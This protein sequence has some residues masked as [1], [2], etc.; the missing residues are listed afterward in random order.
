MVPV[1][2][3][4]RKTTPPVVHLP[5]PCARRRHAVVF[6]GLSRANARGD[7]TA[8]T[9]LGGS[10]MSTPISLA[11]L[12]E[13]FFTQRL[14]QQR[15]ASPHTISSYRD[16]FHQF[17]KFTEQRLRK[18][19]SRLNFQ[20][21]DAPLITTF[22]DHLEKHQGLSTRSRNL[23]LTALR[24]FFRFAA[25]EVPTHSA[26][27]QRV[28]AI[29]SKRFTRTLVQFLT[30][31]EVDALL[32]APDQ[33]TWPWIFCKQASIVGRPERFKKKLYDGERPLVNART[34]AD[35]IRALTLLVAFAEDGHVRSAQL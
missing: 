17:L 7:G 24:S 4:S 25:F 34:V 9:A 28:L 23:R 32:A 1:R 27:I 26:Q 35:H 6:G 13:R 16:T 12:L 15:H 10:A 33:R 8:A 11:A 18:E 20:E 19:P 2:S 30:R 14:M 31:A 21:I 3:G 22:L 5:R 29:P